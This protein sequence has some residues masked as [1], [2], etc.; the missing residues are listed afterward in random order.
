MPGQSAKIS[1]FGRDD[2]KWG[3][4]EPIEMTVMSLPAESEGFAAADLF[5]PKPF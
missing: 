2:M 4:F 1:P 3:I 5:R